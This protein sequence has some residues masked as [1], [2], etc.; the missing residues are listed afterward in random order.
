M[1]TLFLASILFGGTIVGASALA[2]TITVQPGQ[3][4]QEAINWA[5]P[6]DTIYVAPGEYPSFTINRSNISVVSAEPGR[7]RIVASSDR[8]ISSYGQSNVSIVGFRVYAPNSDGI[9]AGGNWKRQVSN[10]RIE[11]VIVE[12]AGKD[13]IK[14]FHVQNSRIIGNRIERGGSLG[15]VGSSDNSNG[16]G[17]ID[18]VRCY[19]TLIQGNN[20]TTQGWA[21]LMLKGGSNGNG[22]KG[23]SFNN[24]DPQGTG[25]AIG[26]TKGPQT[27]DIPEA[28]NNVIED[29]TFTTAGC[30]FHIFA[31][32][33]NN[34][35]DGNQMFQGR[36]NCMTSRGSN[37][38]T[39]SRNG[40]P[41]PIA[42]GESEIPALAGG[43]GGPILDNIRGHH[44]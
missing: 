14:V 39:A 20:V 21:A 22:I 34:Q 31:S 42:G 6:G 5:R 10:V 4:I 35:I 15:P 38:P 29:N 16:D 40:T 43:G 44:R 30:A 19:N 13:G 18:C 33:E 37:G 27:R 41:A 3:N 32:S 23:N 1:R 9:A 24:T 25:M 17:G 2:A 26:G 7:A 36:P 28:S 8:A 12:N 11:G